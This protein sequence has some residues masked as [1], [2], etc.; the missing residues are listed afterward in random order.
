M[1]VA[2]TTKA[3]VSFMSLDYDPF[4]PATMEEAFENC[5]KSAID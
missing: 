2:A 3:I 1:S 5:V 4:Q